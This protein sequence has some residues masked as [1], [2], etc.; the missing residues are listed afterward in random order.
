MRSEVIKVGPEQVVEQAAAVVAVA[1]AVAVGVAVAPGTV[2][3]LLLRRRLLDLYIVDLQWGRRRGRRFR[4]CIA[5]QL[6]EDALILFPGLYLRP[7]DPSA[8]APRAIGSSS[9]SGLDID[10]GRRRQR[11]RAGAIRCFFA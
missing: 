5:V 9:T 8:L 6:V 1:V 4:R 2:G 10:L 7:E 11:L 3:L